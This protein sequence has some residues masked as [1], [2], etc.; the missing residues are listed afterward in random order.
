MPAGLEPESLQFDSAGHPWSPRYGDRF[1]SRAGALAQA[2]HVFLQGN[3]LPQRWAARRQ[4][5]IVETGF[6]L[7][8]NFLAAWQAWRRDAQRPQRLHFV[9]LERHPLRRQDL[10]AATDPDAQDAA[11][12][13]ALRA[14]LAAAWPVALPGLHRL[15]FDAG[16]VVLTLGLGDAR[17][18]AA[19]LVLGADAFFLDGF[20]PD[21]NPELWEPGLLR[22]LARLARPGATLATYT[23]AGAVRRALGDCG[24]EVRR[25]PGFAGKRDMLVG[26]YAPRWP[27]RRHEPPAAYESERRAVI[28]GAGLAGS[29]CALA[30]ARRGWQVT[31]VDACA[32]AT[33]GASALPAGLM[34]PL[35]SADDNL[36][37]RLSRAGYLYAVQ[38]LSRLEAAASAP[39]WQPCG[40]FHQTAGDAERVALLARM[41]QDLVPP[42]YAQGATAAQAAAWLGVAPRHD[43]IWFPGGAV[44]HAGRCCAAMAQ[45]AQARFEG[46]AVSRIESEASGWRVV[47]AQG[48]SHHAPVLILANALAAPDVLGARH[49]PLQA[50]SGRLSLLAPPALADLRAALS[51]D[52]YC[53]P[54]LLGPAAIGASYEGAA[55]PE[56]SA[57]A[58]AHAGNVQR[59]QHL[60]ASAPAVTVK[61]EFAAQRCVAP[62]R[63]PLAGAIAAEGAVLQ[64]LG[65]Y[66][67]AQLEELPRRAGLYCLA[68]LGSRGLSLAPLLGELLAAQISGEPL[69]LER[70]LVAALDPA[71]FLLRH[72]RVQSNRPAPD[73]ALR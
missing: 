68:G 8:S 53:I 60:L 12:V 39:I 41:Q 43:G 18:L 9:S 69:P 7:G 1:A 50:L 5:V 15:E 64:D 61:G 38:A 29:A 63:M 37:S 54:P 27:M 23:S 19:E 35:L 48:H 21:R 22:A 13:A 52:G 28:V 26:R 59:L 14:Q 46:K 40:V 47:D 73:G 66:A 70:R 55:A 6:G 17:R 58:A 56:P 42:E 45:A 32:T 16:A 51:G 36:A 33:G 2:R 71:R 10:D 72:V 24:F 25:A 67:G 49:L 30:L 4:F 44:V 62:D 65:G 57:A 3:E 11:P 34:Y 31:L 20:A